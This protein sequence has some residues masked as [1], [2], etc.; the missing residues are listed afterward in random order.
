MAARAWGV[1]LLCGGGGRAVLLGARGRRW[2]LRDDGARLQT[3]ACAMMRRAAA[4]RVGR[5]L[6]RRQVG[7]RMRGGLLVRCRHGQRR[8]PRV[9][10]RRLK[11]PARLR[12][13]RPARWRMSGCASVMT[14]RRLRNVVCLTAA[15]GKRAT[16]SCPRDLCAALC[17]RA[18][19]CD[20]ALRRV[21][22][23]CVEPGMCVV[24][25]TSGVLCVCLVGWARHPWGCAMRAGSHR[26]ACSG[27]GLC[28]RPPCACCWRHAQW[29]QGVAGG[30]VQQ[31]WTAE[32]MP[33]A[34][35]HAAG[36]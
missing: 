16:S 6:G 4:V 1:L 34:G 35:S 29:L 33:Q 21:A 9:G 14:G 22:L 11:Q 30:W 20:D 2:G 5:R 27:W 12:A 36:P 31:Q 25:G 8:R 23:C 19:S 15:R 18:C 26:F 28:R 7:L 3:G 24:G 13:C 32:C 10:R 17:A